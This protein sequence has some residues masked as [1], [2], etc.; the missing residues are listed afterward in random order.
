[1]TYNLID[2]RHWRLALMNKKISAILI[3]VLLIILFS[4]P[5]SATDLTLNNTPAQIY[6]SPKGGCTEAIV[7]EI[8][9][10]KSE[11]YVQ[12]YSFT[13]A[14]IAK[15]LVDAHK[16]GIKVEAV[17]DKNQKKEKYTSATFLNN[18]GIPTYIDSK[19]AIAHNK[20]MVIDKEIVITGSFNFTKAAEE[21]NAENLLIIKSKE[22]AKIYTENWNEHKDHSDKY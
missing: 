3:A 17:L 8:I 6:F 5:L 1:M 18:A 11:I 22:L 12:A 7:K 19:H 4:I 21:K 2:H 10:A 15:A 20:V 9:Q 13:S 14:P 16:R